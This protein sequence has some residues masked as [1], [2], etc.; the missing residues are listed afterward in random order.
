MR[1]RTFLAGASALAGG[2]LAGCTGGAAPGGGGPGTTTTPTPTPVPTV[3]DSQVETVETGCATGDGG[4]TVVRE[5]EQVR[6]TG[7]L[8]T[9]TPCYLAR[10]TDATYDA[11]ADRLTVAVTAERDPEAMA[12]V[13]CVGEV[14]YEATVTFD[15]GLPGTVVVTHGGEEVARA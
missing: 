4:A 11:D 7:R 13:D 3:T 14:E 9:A 15:G 10:L 5:G 8:R 2:A 12:C 6:V 1:R